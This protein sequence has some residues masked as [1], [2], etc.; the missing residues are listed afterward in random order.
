MN[1]NDDNK[2]LGMERKTF[3]V[4][5]L[6]GGVLIFFWAGSQIS[7]MSPDYLTPLAIVKQNHNTANFYRFLQLISVIA[8]I[9][10]GV[11]VY[12]SYKK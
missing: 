2:I 9:Y 6:I 3:N 11:Q 12:K 4:V 1:N 8:A 7:N 5:L 10:G